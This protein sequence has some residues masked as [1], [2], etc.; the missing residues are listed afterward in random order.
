MGRGKG[1]GRRRGGRGLRRFL[2]PV[3]LL[4]LHHGPAH[5]YSLL[6]GLDEFGFGALDPSM[7]YRILRDMEELEWVT[8]TW[9]EQLTQGPP[10][11]IYQ[12]S[13]RGNEVLAQW[14]KELE[15]SKSRIELFLRVYEQHM[16]EGTGEH[17]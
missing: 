16:K 13:T 11:R 12:L 8:S 3:L 5:G 9:D 17:H 10:R 2:E 15:Q 7:V 6:D 14:V 4:K 1:W